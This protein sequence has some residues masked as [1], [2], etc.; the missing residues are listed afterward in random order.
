M[1]FVSL[2]CLGLSRRPGVARAALVASNY[3]IDMDGVLV[4]GRTLIEGADAFIQR[5]RDKEAPFL[6]LTNNPIYTPRDLAHRL[7]TIGIEVEAERI[8]TS[9]M[10]TASFLK[11]Q[12]P[13][14]PTAFVIGE[15]GVT[16]AL[17]EAGFVITDHDPAYVVLGETHSYNF[18]LITKAVRF[19]AD[20]AH[21]I[22]TNPDVRGP[23]ERGIEPACGALAALMEKAAGVEPFFVGK[24][25]PLMMRTALNYLS[26]HSEDTMMIGDNMQTDII[27]GIQAGLETTLVLSGV[28]GR[29]G[30]QHYSYQPSQVLDSVAQLEV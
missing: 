8:F 3:L 26:V 18:E 24:P 6:L 13:S 29:K 7:K 9:A 28:T 22:A 17:H 16:E 10:A 5:L 1:S 2:S 12:R 11:G 14:N 21:F 27:G 4:R 15:S 20:G 25:N 19:L 23:T 30:Y